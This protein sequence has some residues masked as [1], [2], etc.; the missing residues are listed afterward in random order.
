MRCRCPGAAPAWGARGA[1]GRGRTHTAGTAAQGVV[2][3][4]RC[5]DDTL[6]ERKTEGGRKHSGCGA[7]RRKDSGNA[8]RSRA[9]QRAEEER[10]RRRRVVQ[11]GG[12]D[13]RKRCVRRMVRR[14]HSPSC[15]RGTRGRARVCQHRGAAPAG[16]P[17]AAP[18][19]D[20]R[21]RRRRGVGVSG[22]TAAHEHVQTSAPRVRASSPGCSSR[23]CSA[24][25]ARRLALVAGGKGM[26]P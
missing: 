23:L 4:H 1:S 22:V 10:G 13:R 21:R 11:R 2:R 17:G 14:H 8:A 15:T 5:F 9:G 25:W 18:G 6:V 26:L 12:H 7:H 20:R 3:W 24:G 19:R 16:R